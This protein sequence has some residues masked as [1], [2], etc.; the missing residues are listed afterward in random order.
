MVRSSTPNNQPIALQSRPTWQ[1][2]LVLTWP[3]LLQMM[4]IFLVS[5]SDSLLAGRFVPEKGDHVAAQSAQTTATYLTWLLSNYVALVSV[6]STALVS[7]FVGAGDRNLAIR[8]TNQAMVLA[9]FFGGIGTVIGL[10]TTTPL[11]RLLGLREDEISFA[12]SYLQ[13]LFLALTF[14]IIAQGGIACLVGAGDTRTGLCVLGMVAILNVP[15]SWAFFHG[16][17]PFPKLGFPGI[18]WGTA[19]GHLLAGIVVLIILSVG[20]AGLQLSVPFLRPDF[21]LIRRMLRISVPA[22]MDGMAVMLGQLWFL[23][24][25]NELPKESTGAHGIALRCEAISYLSGV[26]FGTAAM[27]LIGQNLGARRLEQAAQS[28]WT[29]FKLGLAVMCFT[30]A[31]FYVLA[32]QLFEL[33]CPYPHQKPLIEKG[34]PVLRLIAF[35]MPPLACTIILSYALRGAG[36]TRIAVLFSLTGF[37]LVRVPLAS[38]LTRDV[39]DLGSWGTFE[40][41]GMG[42]LGAWI[43]MVVDLTV[44]GAFFLWRFQSKRWQHIEV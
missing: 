9:L 7:R 17:G 3:V 44:R 23:S 16:W 38:Y 31:I 42:L 26:A 20:R 21:G 18:A 43:A 33:F 11:V 12:V 1:L 22:G 32:P 15:F 14:Q 2:V 13:P 40:G 5:L 24:I 27:T 6:G 29:A 10:T 28:V 4:L 30:G 41:G 19:V 37:F 34:I 25:V 35:G 39:I 36:D 8:T